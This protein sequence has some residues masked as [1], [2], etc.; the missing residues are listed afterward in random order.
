MVRWDP[1]PLVVFVHGSADL[2]GSDRVL[3]NLVRDC[4]A[5][6][7]WHVVVVLGESGPLH[8][9]LR[10]AG[11]EVHL[12][13]VGKIAR[14]MLSWRAPLSLWS[15]LRRARLEL[16]RVVSGRPV[17]LVYSNTLAVLGGAWCAHRWRRPHVWHVHETVMQPRLV[18]WVLGRLADRMADHVVANSASTRRWLLRQAPALAPRCRV[19][20]N[21]IAPMP[22]ASPAEIEAFRARVGARHGE[23]VIACVGRFNHL[24]GQDLLIEATA[25]L[26]RQGRL[27]PVRV[28]IVG[29]VY[30]GHEDF[31][32]H[33]AARIEQH[34]LGAHVFLLPFERDIHRVWRGS[35]IA[36]VPSVQPEGFGL[37]AVEAM[38]CGLPVVAAA[39]GGVTEI[40]EHGSSGWLF[41]PGRVDDLAHAL[42]C[43][44]RDAPLRRRLGAQAAEQQSVRFSLGAQLARM[45]QVLAESTC[46]A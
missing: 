7:R 24:K 28:A 37:V 26:H 27:G 42:D 13:A 14:S 40:V 21:G 10:Q 46:P 20:H 3:L 35:D 39:H 31:R 25:R 23:V 1:R 11:A 16:E 18:G 36:V 8:E 33:L 6:G 43:L 41:E 2:Y 44:V 38:A 9:E 32:A 12:A 19:V 4:T 15:S 45:R 22:A 29:D 17:A 30:A 5:Q 34:G